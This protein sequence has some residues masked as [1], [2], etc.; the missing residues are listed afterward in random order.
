MN[1]TSLCIKLSISEWN[2]SLRSAIVTVYEEFS[3]K[4]RSLSS[5]PINFIAWTKFSSVRKLLQTSIIFYACESKGMYCIWHMGLQ[6]MKTLKIS[7]SRSE[8]IVI[9]STDTYL[10]LLRY[11]WHK[12]ALNLNHCQKGMYN[13]LWFCYLILHGKSLLLFFKDWCFALLCCNESGKQKGHVQW[14]GT[15]CAFKDV[16]ECLQSWFF[17]LTGTGS[18]GAN[19]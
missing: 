17:L 6:C 2:N 15:A 12:K 14:R 7:N 10:V 19:S 4:T 16:N 8:L 11:L 9:G 5:P 18:L 1:Q 3:G 13:L